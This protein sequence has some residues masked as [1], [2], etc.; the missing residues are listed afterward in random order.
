MRAQTDAYRDSAY[1]LP[2]ALDRAQDAV[3]AALSAVFCAAVALAEARRVGTALALLV[4]YYAGGALLVAFSGA[5]FVRPILRLID[6]V[7]L[8]RDRAGDSQR[9]RFRKLLV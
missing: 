3:V 8:E 7:Q 6:S 9:S 4:A 2:R 5:L 1:A